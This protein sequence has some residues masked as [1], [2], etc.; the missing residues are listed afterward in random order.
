MLDAQRL[1]ES[2]QSRSRSR[3][4]SAPPSQPSTPSAAET[5]NEPILIESDSE[6]NPNGGSSR[7]ASASESLKRKRDE[8]HGDSGRQ[9]KRGRGDPEPN[10]AG[11]SSNAGDVIVIEDDD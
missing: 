5:T 10:V 3:T 2:I 11:P 8:P 7:L 1:F 6:E 9:E 4:S